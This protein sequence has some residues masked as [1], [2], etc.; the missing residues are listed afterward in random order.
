MKRNEKQKYVVFSQK[1]AG[2]LLL[3][4]FVLQAIEVT[5]QVNSK[6]NVFIFNDSD[7]I[8]KTI[9]EYDSFFNEHRDYF[10]K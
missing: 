5:R 4:G 2:F 3:H 8:R 10:I 6:R 7:Q 1:V 9:A